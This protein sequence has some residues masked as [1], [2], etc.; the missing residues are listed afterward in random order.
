MGKDVILILI[1]LLS[2][3]IL[4]KLTDTVE[5]ADHDE[6]G[7]WAR[8]LRSII[9]PIC[10]LEDKLYDPLNYNCVS[11]QVRIRPP[12]CRDNKGR[13]I[14]CTW[15]GRGENTENDEKLDM[16]QYNDYACYF[17][18]FSPDIQ[19]VKDVEGTIKALTLD[20]FERRYDFKGVWAYMNEKKAN[21]SGRNIHYWRK[22]LGVSRY[23]SR[24][25]VNT[26]YNT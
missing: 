16:C 25:I 23:D 1:I 9:Q 13:E 22:I 19:S 21:P 11:P 7:M 3:K 6:V 20:F 17:L 2:Y 15:R 18:N 8:F 5:G 14:P 24:K 12:L 4:T 10:D 26:K